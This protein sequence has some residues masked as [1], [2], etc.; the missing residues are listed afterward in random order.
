MANNLFVNR[1]RVLTQDGQVAYDERFHHGVNII[2]GDNSSGKSTITHLLFYGLGGEYTRFVEQARRCS[3]VLVEV[4]IDD[5]TVT[6]ERPL[7]KD[8]EG[9]VKP[10]QA[11][12]LHWGDMD[13]TMG[14]HCR[15]QRM[16]YATTQEREGFSSVLFRL[17]GIPQVQAD[18]RITMHQLLRLIYVDQESPS[19]SVFMHEQFDNQSTR[20]A[21]ADLLM[22]IFES[23]LYEARAHLRDL[24]TRIA[25]TKA[26]LHTAHATLP[27]EAHSCKRVK[28]LIQDKKDEMEQ[29]EHDISRLRAGE[30]VES[31]S[32]PL[33]Q[34]QKA[35]VAGLALKCNQLEEEADL[36]EHEVADTQFFL[37]ALRCKREA[38][39]QSAWAG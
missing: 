36:L 21:V 28:G 29:L 35:E 9:R 18:S 3:R 26:A 24:E 1:L 33:I 22:G 38:L 23:G 39:E 5:A 31:Q 34:Q 15:S 14:G 20:E 10:R 27:A 25:D 12:T 6:L 8:T 17:M 19:W 4:S 32:K 13:D 30:Q 16:G 37:D 7:D 11:M 2:R